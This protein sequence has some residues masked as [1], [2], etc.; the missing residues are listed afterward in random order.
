[1]HRIIFLIQN[2]SSVF[3]VE[4]DVYMLK[5]YM[6]DFRVRVIIKVSD[7]KLRLICLVTVATFYPSSHCFR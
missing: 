4:F 6:W 7:A 3:R 1:M 2:Q 5:M